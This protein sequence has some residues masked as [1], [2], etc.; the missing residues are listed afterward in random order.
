MLLQIAYHLDHVEGM[1]PVVADA[2]SLL[3]NLM[4][5]R[6]WVILGRYH[7]RQLRIVRHQVHHFQTDESVIV[8]N[9]AHSIKHNPQL[10]QLLSQNSL[11]KTCQAFIQAA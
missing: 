4:V 7:R 3:R 6:A 9:Q 10:H 5:P 11:L 2:I 8:V 1:P